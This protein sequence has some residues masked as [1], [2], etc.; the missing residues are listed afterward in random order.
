MSKTVKSKILMRRDTSLNWERN[1][2]ILAAGQVGFDITVGKHKIGDGQHRWTSLPYFALE[3]D[4]DDRIT[5]IM[6]TKQEWQYWGRE[7]SQKGIFYIYTDNEVIEEGS[8]R[9]QIPGI[10]IG[11]GLAYIC[12]LPFVTDYLSKILW[13]H[14]ND[15][16]IHITQQE[17]EFWNNKVTSYI[18]GSNT[19]NL[20]LDKGTLLLE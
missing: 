1:N 2:P 14:V 8:S 4:L 3:T 16:I 15:K 18:N 12:D 5:F 7:L 11:D 9:I 17:R 10:K 6:K 20:V 19:N 13:E